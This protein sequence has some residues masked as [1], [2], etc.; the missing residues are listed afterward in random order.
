MV[1]CL[2]NDLQID[3]AAMSSCVCLIHIKGNASQ[4]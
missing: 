4:C 3:F 1:I 2:S